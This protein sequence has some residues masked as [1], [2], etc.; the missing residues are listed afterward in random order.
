M[1]SYEVRS[2]SV[3]KYLGRTLKQWVSGQPAPA[4]EIRERL[5]RNALRLPVRRSRWSSFRL[6]FARFGHFAFETFASVIRDEEV[7]Y[8]QPVALAH[9]HAKGLAIRQR[10]ARQD[11]FNVVLCTLGMLGLVC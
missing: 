4:M 3:D 2:D 5:L 1:S 11:Q 9:A 7:L 6:G 8:L 10:M